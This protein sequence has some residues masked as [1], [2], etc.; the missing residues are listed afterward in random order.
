MDGVNHPSD[1]H[2]PRVAG[3]LWYIPR[4]LFVLMAPHWEEEE[5]RCKEEE[6]IKHLIRA[7][8]RK[9]TRFLGK[10]VQFFC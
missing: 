4:E 1:G 3:V 5:R 9:M 7:R 2:P 6:K 8:G 10:H